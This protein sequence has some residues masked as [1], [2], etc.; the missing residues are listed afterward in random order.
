MHEPVLLLWDDFSEHWRTDVLILARLL[1]G[2]LLKVPP[3]YS[4]V[5]QPADV[6]W[7]QPFKSRLRQQWVEFLVAQVRAAGAAVAFKML[8]PTRSELVTCIKDA[9]AALSTTTIMAGFRKAGVDAGTQPE[10]PVALPFSPCSVP[11]LSWM[12]MLLRA[13]AATTETVDAAKDIEEAC[14]EATV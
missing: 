12:V 4:Y 14:D 13:H 9:W 5:C 8:P 3:G 7:N 10:E 6:A 11:D 2:E 1:N